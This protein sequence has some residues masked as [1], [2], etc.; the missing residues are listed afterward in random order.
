MPY[1]AEW[2]C[3]D[4]WIVLL[5]RQYHL[6]T[7]LKLAMVTNEVYHCKAERMLC[8]GIQYNT[9]HFQ[10]TPDGL[11]SK[12]FVLTLVGLYTHHLGPYVCL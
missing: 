9:P 2:W 12:L 11:Y 1:L 4:H 10:I 6:R 3:F 7:V 5:Q 8:N